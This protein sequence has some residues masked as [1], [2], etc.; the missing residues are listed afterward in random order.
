MSLAFGRHERDV[1]GTG[2]ITVCDGRQPLHMGT[3]HFGHRRLFGLAQLGE[4]GGY[5]R[6]RTVMLTDLHPAH[7][8]GKSVV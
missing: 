2:A 7:R 1:G 6:H 4:F 3:Q 5:V 8:P